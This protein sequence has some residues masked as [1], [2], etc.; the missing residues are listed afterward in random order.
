MISCD[1][2]HLQS[3]YLLPSLA[4]LECGRDVH[5]HFQSDL[6]D[7]VTGTLEWLSPVP[8]SHATRLSQ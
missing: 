8:S 3:V 4:V 2:V 5:A 1:I 6:P 7:A